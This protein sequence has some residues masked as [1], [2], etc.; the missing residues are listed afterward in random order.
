MQARRWPIENPI[1]C[2][3]YQLDS[4][5]FCRDQFTGKLLRVTEKV[6]ETHFECRI[7]GTLYVMK[8]S[9]M[10]IVEIGLKS[11]PISDELYPRDSPVGTT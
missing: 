7:E 4:L 11:R 5:S 2:T 3:L 9:V 8:V 10:G 6:A 1:Y